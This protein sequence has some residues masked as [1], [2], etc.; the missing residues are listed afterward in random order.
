MA[1]HVPNSDR[2]VSSPTGQCPKKECAITVLVRENSGQQ[3][4][5]S[6][7]QV[8][9][10]QKR[11]TK[12]TD[13]S[14]LAEFKGIKPPNRDYTVVAQL[15]T[16]K[17]KKYFWV[18]QSRQT[19]N[20]PGGVDKFYLMEVEKLSSLKV[21][22]R[23]SDNNAAVG[24]VMIRISGLE[25]KNLR[26]ADNTG[27]ASFKP[28][29]GG[30]YTIETVLEGDHARMFRRPEIQNVDVPAGTDG[31]VEIRLEPLRVYLQLVYQDPEA[32]AHFFPRGF[33]VS[34]VF[35]DNTKRD[36][37]VAD[38][39]GNLDFGIEACKSSFTLKFESAQVR[40]LVH[41]K[42][43]TNNLTA[44]VLQNQSDDQLRDLTLAGKRFFSLPKKFALATSR[45]EA[46]RA[47]LSAAGQITIPADG[48]GVGTR[49]APARLILKPQFLHVR[50]EFFDRKYGHKNHT[51]KRIS[52]PP[53]VLKGTRDCDNGTSASPDT[54]SNWQV[55]RADAFKACQALPWILTKK[56]ED[57]TVLPKL[58][59]KLLLEFG[60][61]E[62]F[63]ASESATER[64]IE[65]IP[66][67]NAK[68]KPSKDRPKYYDL[69]GV[70]KCKNY[71]TRLSD[72]T[73][74]FFDVITD[75]DLE[76]AYALEKA[77]AFSLDDIVLIEGNSQDVK[78][79]DNAD[80]AKALSADSRVALLYLDYNDAFKVKVHRPQAKA[81]YHS[82]LAFTRNVIVDYNPDTRVV[83]FCSGF[84]DVFDKRTVEPADFTK[85]QIVGARA[86]KLDDADVHFKAAIRAD[87]TYKAC[88]AANCGN[89]DLHFLQYGGVDD[90]KGQMIF[91]QV[92]FWSCR[93][94]TGAGGTAANVLKYREEGFANAMTRWNA[95]DYEFVPTNRNDAKGKT[96][97]M[98]EAKLDAA[99][100]KHKCEVTI[101]DENT[102]SAIGLDT[103]HFR[104]AAYQNEPARFG[105]A[106][107]DYDGKTYECL[108]VAHE[109]G[110]GTGL[111]DSYVYN[112]TSLNGD[113]WS[114]LPRY[115]QYYKG[116]PYVID[117][118]SLM[119]R[120]QGLRLRQYWGKASWLHDSIAS[121]PAMQGADRFQVVYPG[122]TDLKYS[123]PAG[124]TLKDVYTPKHEQA[125]FEWKTNAKCDLFL[126]RLGADE[127]SHGLTNGQFYNGILAV[128]T[129]IRLDFDGIWTEAAK[130][131]WGQTLN[132][133]MNAGLNMRYHLARKSGSG[134]F[135]NTLVRFFWQFTE[136]VNDPAGAHHFTL[137]VDDNGDSWR[138]ALTNKAW[139]FVGKDC[140][141]N[142]IICFLLGIDPGR[143][144]G[145]S[146]W[147]R[148]WIYDEI[149]TSDFNKLA[150]W[151]KTT[152]GVDYK[153]QK[154]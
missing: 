20:V 53:I 96:Y 9:V 5:V 80:A 57:L 49:T 30:N 101:T 135:D 132:N 97:N 69:P 26:T 145:V 55:Q 29:R 52:I 1:N 50:F 83:V 154:L 140:P 25:Q 79:K 125:D 106:T 76:A 75:A 138:V 54:V 111:K 105:A 70:W 98:F 78:D 107:A 44:Q 37:Q 18:S 45:W 82:D 73:G 40:C 123:R 66:A 28:I 81:A 71:Y 84:Y 93:L 143:S 104:A 38:D 10:T 102:G 126:Y 130:E 41:E 148:S 3:A 62:G 119:F 150:G 87:G 116:M 108:A 86:A 128:T 109:L 113:T 13:A 124:E 99:G 131:T 47:T 152:V 51:D 142:K 14:G 42:P 88:T 16:E 127:F 144:S 31:T 67:G 122:K 43:D 59:K 33:P 134:E 32:Q 36:L 77:I 68:R 24:K 149:E 23:R 129:R 137:T 39:N 64:K 15:S 17:K 48:N 19:K 110:H 133:T 2:Q 100:G 12:T 92:T 95:K 94:K 141:T 6:G 35:N 115:E 146:G 136:Q 114:G 151:M 7:V 118:H 27:E 22:V 11:L 120:N 58:D 74:K 56:E 63:I 117:G 8:D 89:F 139:L 90:A 91:A 4:G 60:W 72:G 61:P 65:K 21:T 46:E 103:A 34:V 153:I 121:L 112:M 147:F 85:Q